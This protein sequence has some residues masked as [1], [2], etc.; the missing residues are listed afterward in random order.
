MSFK[1]I[2][3][4]SLTVVLIWSCSEEN[5]VAPQLELTGKWKNVLT[6]N[7]GRTEI[8]L[9]FQADSSFVMTLSHYGLQPNT[10]PDDLNAS[11]E[12]PGTLTVTE[13]RIEFNINEYTYTDYYFETGP[14]TFENRTV[15]YDNCTYVIS[16]DTLILSYTSYPA[17]APIAAEQRFLRTE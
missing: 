3:L 13:D 11:L 17:D 9:D 6:Q 10:A 4:L 5:E 15:F 14:E 8:L 2:I 16:G 1:T 12:Y 7:A